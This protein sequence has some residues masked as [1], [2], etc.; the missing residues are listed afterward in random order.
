LAISS[1]SGTN[2]RQLFMSRWQG[3]TPE[4][5]NRFTVS[6]QKPEAFAKSLTVM[7][8]LNTP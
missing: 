5:A 1:A 4:S 6:G 8:I 2:T 7:R 3:S